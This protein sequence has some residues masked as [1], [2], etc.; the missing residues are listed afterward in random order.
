MLV[1]GVRIWNVVW[2]HLN[3]FRHCK[4]TL[5]AGWWEKPCCAVHGASHVRARWGVVDRWSV[6]AALSDVIRAVLNPRHR[7]ACQTLSVLILM[8]W[9]DLSFPVWLGNE[10]SREVDFIHWEELTTG[11][12]VVENV[13]ESASVLNG[14]VCYVRTIFC[15]D[16]KRNY[17]SSLIIKQNILICLTHFWGCHIWI[18]WYRC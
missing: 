10:S 8:N 5:K 9:W 13:C 18:W 2:L 6:E 3:K 17:D 15:N 16:P 12:F 7:W 14:M 4:D 1:L 11:P